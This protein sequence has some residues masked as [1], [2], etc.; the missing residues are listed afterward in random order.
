MAKFFVDAVLD[1]LLEQINDATLMTVCNAP[2]T[3]YAEMSAT[4][5]LADVV[6][7][8]GDFT[9]SNGDTNGRKVRVAA[10]SAVPIDTSGDATHVALAISGSSTLLG[11]TTCT[12][13][14]LTALGTVDI[15]VWDVEVADPT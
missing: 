6:M 7:A 14:T 4:F 15:P 10:K 5:K 8:G 9:I 11:A 3:T 12:T 1:G 13:Q 2:P